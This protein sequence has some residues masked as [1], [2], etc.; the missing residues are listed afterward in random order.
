MKEE[1]ETALESLQGVVLCGGK[2]KITVA[3]LQ[4]GQ[5]DCFVSSS[6]FLFFLDI[7]SKENTQK[8]TI[9]RE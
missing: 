3:I 1:G 6:S 2:R 5:Q 4:L 9:Y 8:A 7:F